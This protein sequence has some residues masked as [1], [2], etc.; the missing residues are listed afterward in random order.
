MNEFHAEKYI[1]Q[2]EH[3]KKLELL[4]DA[5]LNQVKRKRNNFEVSIRNSSNESNAKEYLEYIK[6]EL[7]LLKKFKQI[8]YQNENDFRAIDRAVS[9]NVKDLFRQALKKYQDNRKIWGHYLSFAKSK[10]PNSVTYIYQD[11]LNFHHSIE[12]YMEAV[13]HEMSTSNYNLAISF[14]IQGMNKERNSLELVALHIECSLKQADEEGDKAFKKNTLTQVD[15]LYTKFIKE[16]NDLKIHIGLLQSI[17]NFEFA[18]GFQNTVLIDLLQAFPDRAETWNIL[19]KRHLD[20]LFFGGDS[21]VEEKSDDD[22]EINGNDEEKKIIPFETRLK[23]ALAIYDKSFEVLENQPRNEMYKLYINRLLELD[24]HSNIDY[25]CLKYIRQAL[26]KA[27]K[28]AYEED[29]LSEQH[30]VYYLKLCMFHDDNSTGIREMLERSHRLY[31]LNLELFELAIK[32]YLQLK[33]YERITKVFNHAIHFNEKSGIE[34]YKFICEIYLKNPDD[35]EKA[36]HAMMEAINSSNK[37]L[38]ASFQPYVIEYYAL[39]DGIERAR[40][41]FATLIKSKTVTSLSLEFYQI[42][43]KL[44]QLQENPDYLI[45]GNCFERAIEGFGKESSEVKFKNLFKKKTLLIPSGADF[46]FGLNTQNIFGHRINSRKQT[47]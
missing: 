24:E 13:K 10:F 9:R 7:A 33:D 5:E 35:K 4:T 14:L 31:P 46:R 20:G 12:D 16:S 42:M 22:D 1:D 43:I 15:K 36:R 19:A 47:A 6:Y 3:I 25:I 18:I 38:S 21:K 17:Q 34:L 27:F 39:T 29:K 11:M 30:F 40:E 32:Y 45:I 28:D 26:G 23:H 8:E 44:E 41:L 37:K 2:Y